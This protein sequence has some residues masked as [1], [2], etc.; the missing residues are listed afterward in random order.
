MKKLLVLTIVSLFLATSCKKVTDDPIS[1]SSAYKTLTTYMVANDMDLPDILT[2]WIVPAPALADVQTFINTYDIIDIRSAAD[3]AAGHIE[4]AVNSTLANVLTTA[5]GTT[6]PILVVCYTGQ[7]AAHA[8]VALKLSGYTAKVLMW[9][10]SGW[11]STL[12]GS[13]E[14]NSGPVNGIT[15]IGHTNWVTTPTTSLA[16]F[17][18]PDI[19]GTG[20]AATMLATRVQTMLDNGFKGV[21]NTDVLDA[22]SNY[23]I[24]V[25][26][27]Q[28]D[29]DT[30]GHIAEAYRVNPLTL[31]VGEMSNLD[32][33]Q[34]I[35]T[36]CWTGQTSSMITA[37]LNVIGYDAASL[38]FGANGMIYTD[39]QSHK[40][41]TPTVDLPIVQ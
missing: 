2:D 31:S 5:A 24:N 27:S 23:F 33:S 36:Y 19:T 34:K 10:M 1:N 28:A 39:L 25:Y 38:K 14:A 35:V 37:Y 15:A 18:D 17:G 21:T 30:Y 40:Y 8:V 41:V 32:P 6:K 9:G 4:G 13:W 29:V 7:S 16:T 26:W 22:P 20:D 12:S 3:Y 11:T